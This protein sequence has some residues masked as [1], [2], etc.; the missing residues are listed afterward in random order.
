[1]PPKKK[2]APDEMPTPAAAP[3]KKDGGMGSVIALGVMLVLFA[4]TVIILLSSPQGKKLLSRAPAV[5]GNE[6]AP[7]ANEPSANANVNA[8]AEPEL[9]EFGLPA[10][11]QVE[12]V[13]TMDADNVVITDQRLVWRTEDGDTVLVASINALLPALPANFEALFLFAR[14]TGDRKV[15]FTRN[16]NG[17]CDGKGVGIL[18]FDPAVRAFI[19][20]LNVPDVHTAD[21]ELSPNQRRAAYVSGYDDDGET[22]ELWVYD[23]IGD[24]RTRIVTLPEGETFTRALQEIDESADFQVSWVDPTQLTYEVYRAGGRVPFS[25]RARTPIATRS[26]SVPQ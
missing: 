13:N 12:L 24:S 14:P 2:S 3:T 10:G 25:E 11:G 9:N 23:L 6:N 1:M 21:M 4:G 8:P 26:V 15:Y 16:C 19:P 17:G 22:R 7:A 20:L 5:N 18:A